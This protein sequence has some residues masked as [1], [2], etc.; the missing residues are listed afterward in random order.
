[1]YYEKGAGYT[2]DPLFIWQRLI[3][4]EPHREQVESVSPRVTQNIYFLII[5][6]IFAGIFPRVLMPSFL[7][8]K[9]SNIISFMACIR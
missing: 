5:S 7:R 2:A 1:M 9:G 3:W 8:M 6:P 4:I